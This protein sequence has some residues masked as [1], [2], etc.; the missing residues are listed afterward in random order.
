M[1]GMNGASVSALCGPSDAEH[2]AGEAL[3][4]GVVVGLAY[5]GELAVDYGLS[6]QRGSKNSETTDEDGS[7]GREEQTIDPDNISG[8]LQEE[9]TAQRTVALRAALMSR[10]DVALV[11][12]THKLAGLLFLS[13]I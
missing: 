6:N 11:A 4:A 12:I 13:R 9:L 3:S 1:G 2:R 7:V 10:P 5:K 8:S